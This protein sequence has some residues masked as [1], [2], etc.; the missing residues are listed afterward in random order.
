MSDLTSPP[1][2]LTLSRHFDASPDRVYDAWTGQDW[3]DWLPPRGATCKVT[4]IDPRRGGQFQAAMSMPD[5]RHIV[6]YGTY[7]DVQ[8]PERLVFTWQGDCFNSATLVTLTF[9]PDGA[10]TLMTLRQEGFE[11]DAMR[12]GF[13]NGWSG[14]GGS[15]DKLAAFLKQEAAHG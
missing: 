10:G 13:E 11:Q 15:F 6:V 2:T 1:L 8:R 9:K 3:G 7:R 5:G 12:A 14:E 4:A